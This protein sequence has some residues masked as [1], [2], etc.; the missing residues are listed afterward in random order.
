MGVFASGCRD[1]AAHRAR[2]QQ[3]GHRVLNDPGYRA[4]QVVSDG[5]QSA[6]HGCACGHHEIA[7]TQPG[8]ENL[9]KAADENDAAAGY[10]GVSTAIRG[11]RPMPSPCPAAAPACSLSARAASPSASLVPAVTMM[12]AA[13]RITPRACRRCSAIRVRRAR[14]PC[15]GGS[16]CGIG[17][18]AALR[19]AAVHPRPFNRRVDG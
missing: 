10:P 14:V 13:V 15:S 2:R 5:R 1:V 12:S 18:F 17:P 8:S 9:G 16:A 11:T 6:T 19:H 4:G 7:Q 3:L